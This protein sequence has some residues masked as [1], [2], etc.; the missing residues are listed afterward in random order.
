MYISLDAGEVPPVVELRESDNFKEF[1]VVLTVPA[2]AWIDPSTL[3]SLAGRADD[4]GWSGSFSTMITYAE[5]QG[6][7]DERGRIQA[8]IEI[9][10]PE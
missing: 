3:V 2:H 9:R 5:R 6:W 7:L 4:V 1:S 10:K 8:H